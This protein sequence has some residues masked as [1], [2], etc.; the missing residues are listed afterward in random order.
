MKGIE[1]SRRFYEECGRPVLQAQFGGILPLLAV[2]C[3]GSGSDRYGFDDEVSRDHDFEPGFCIFLP[4]ESVI[5]RRTEFALQR[6]YDKLPR[7]F[8]GV[9]R[10]IGSPV[11]GARNG[12]IRTAEFYLQKAGSPTGELST[13]QWLVSPD[14]A[15]ADATN[16][17]V[18]YDGYGEFSRIRDKLLNMPDDVRLKKLAGDLLLM[19]Q[20]GQYNYSRCIAHGEYESAQLAL[21]GFTDAALKVF[22]LLHKKYMPFYKWAFR[23][24]RA[25]DGGDGF[26]Q[27]LAAL[28]SGDIYAVDVCDGKRRAVEEVCAVVVGELKKQRLTTQT[29][30]D[31]ERHAYSVNDGIKDAELRNADVLAAV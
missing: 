22:F 21:G 26:A 13:A 18:F 5:D 6:A 24:L 15:L 17:E 28:M 11:G 1:L 30:S 16:G 14:Y 31:L 10:Q 7:E 2:G 23:A 25:L 3:V 27:R 19:A 12:T 29:C 4:D 9:K 8:M 20:S